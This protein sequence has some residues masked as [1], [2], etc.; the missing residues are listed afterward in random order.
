M[1]TKGF[2]AEMYAGLLLNQNAENEVFDVWVGN[3]EELTRIA[4][5]FESTYNCTVI[6]EHARMITVC[7]PEAALPDSAIY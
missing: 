4:G 7:C 5:A 2:S 6:R 1:W 3:E